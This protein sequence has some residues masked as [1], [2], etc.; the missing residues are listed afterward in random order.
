MDTPVELSA[1]L[2]APAVQE[3]WGIFNDPEYLE[4][5][6]A[7]GEIHP[8]LREEILE[9]PLWVSPIPGP[10]KRFQKYHNEQRIE[11]GNNF[12][13]G[14]LILRMRTIVQNPWRDVKGNEWEEIDDGRRA[15]G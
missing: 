6:F 12:R 15:N 3:E 7:S 8:L 13:E 2:A 10:A 9:K 5:R 14:L 11:S 4:P 1:V